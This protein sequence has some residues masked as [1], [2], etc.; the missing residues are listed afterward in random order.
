[1]LKLIEKEK[2]K[3][4][5]L[6]RIGRKEYLRMEFNQGKEPRRYKIN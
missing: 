6:R 5:F 4:N 3:R 1:L 2:G